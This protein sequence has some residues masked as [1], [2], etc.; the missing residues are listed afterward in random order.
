MSRII[1][2]LPPSPKAKYS[3]RFKSPVFCF[4]TKHLLGDLIPDLGLV[5]SQPKEPGQVLGPEA[6]FRLD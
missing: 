5:Q 6:D 3:K 1:T 2:L 4:F